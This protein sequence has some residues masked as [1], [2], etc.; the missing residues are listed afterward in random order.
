MAYPGP[1]V[2]ATFG[3]TIYGGADIWS[4]GLN[5]YNLPGGGLAVTPAQLAAAALALREPISEWFES[6]GAFIS[7]YANL[8]WVKVAALDA[9]GRYIE[10]SQLAEVNPSVNGVYET[11]VA[12]QISTVISLTTSSTRGLAHIGRIYPPLSGTAS[13]TGYIGTNI[14]DGMAFAASLLVEGVNAVTED[15][16]GEGM[17]VSILSKVGA[18]AVKEVTGVRVGNVLDTQRSR[19]NAFIETYTS[20]PLTE[21]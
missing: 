19:R 17:K 11:A 15:V 9:Q 2:K 14:V 8:E 13:N 18:G 5:I 4:C 10:D 20:Y 7:S 21:A 1:F 12:P 6:A 3:G 16:F